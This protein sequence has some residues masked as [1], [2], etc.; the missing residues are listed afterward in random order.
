M[1][2]LMGALAA[3]TPVSWGDAATSLLLAFGLG[4]VLAQLYVRTFHGLS[5]SRNFVQSMALGSVVT[6]TLMLAIG[7]SIA[8]GI[9]IAGGLSIVRFRATMRDPRDMVFIFAS[10]AV[11]IVCGLRSYPAAITGTA[12]FVVGTFLMEA[13]DY[14]AQR[15]HDGLIRLVAPPDAEEE[16]ARVLRATCRR[17]TLVTLR[18]VAQGA[19]MEHAWQVGLNDPDERGELVR[20]LQA[21]A[22]VQDVSLL[23]QEATLEL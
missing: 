21:V 8:A 13:M 22:G 20:R 4:Q 12:V 10:L 5:Y 9:G 19:A 23:L 6:A 7:G 1:T 14:G 18:E 3:A 17:F 15:Q 2:D 11:G 16:I